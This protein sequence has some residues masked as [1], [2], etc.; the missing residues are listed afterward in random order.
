MNYEDFKKKPYFPHIEDSSK[1]VLCWSIIWIP[2]QPGYYAM[3]LSQTILLVEEQIRL[4]ISSLN[5]EKVLIFLEKN[6]TL[7]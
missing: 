5:N 1:M 2:A 4:G 3:V 7:N 6:L